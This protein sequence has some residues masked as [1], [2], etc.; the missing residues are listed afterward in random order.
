M[1]VTMDGPMILTSGYLHQNNQVLKHIRSGM[2][3]TRGG[4]ACGKVN[5]PA[6]TVG[7]MILPFGRTPCTLKK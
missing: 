5:L 7:H 3:L 2:Q 4:I 6:L 1:W